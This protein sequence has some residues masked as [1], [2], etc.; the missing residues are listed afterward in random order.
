MFWG[1]MFLDSHGLVRGMV[2]D[3]D[4]DPSIIKKKIAR[5]NLDFYCFVISF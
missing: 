5:K 2:P 3:P 1:H 4:S